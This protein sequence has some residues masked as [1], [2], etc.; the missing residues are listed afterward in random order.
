MTQYFAL[1]L[2]RPKWLLYVYGCY[3]SGRARFWIIDFWEI[4][5]QKRP[6]QRADR[7]STKGCHTQVMLLHTSKFEQMSRCW[8]NEA[9]ATYFNDDTSV[10]TT[11][12]HIVNRQSS[13]VGKPGLWKHF[14]IRRWIDNSWMTWAW[15]RISLD[16]GDR[17]IINQK[18]DIFIPNTID[19]KIATKCV[20][21]KNSITNLTRNRNYNKCEPTL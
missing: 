3:M 20:T 9:M 5:L 12:N 16:F 13:G 17:Q 1:S 15:I 6:L 4:I 21:R 14:Q 8:T 18:I 7:R 10:H 11:S 2:C 19:R